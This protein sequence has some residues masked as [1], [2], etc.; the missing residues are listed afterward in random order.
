MRCC[1]QTGLPS[2]E[3]EAEV[4]R[5]HA[6]SGTEGVDGSLVQIFESVATFPPANSFV[7]LLQF[8]TRWLVVTTR[9]DF[10]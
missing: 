2:P 1:R 10:P 3:F 8:Q 7:I 9:A 6:P 4:T 5:T